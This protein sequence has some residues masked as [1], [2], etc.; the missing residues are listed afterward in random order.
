MGT[1]SKFADSP[2]QIRKEGQEITLRFTKTGPTTGRV[3]W[4]IPLPS[5]G[6]DV[7][8]AGAYN[9]IVITVASKAANYLSTSPQNGTFYTGD[10]SVDPDLNTGDRLDGAMVLAALY[11]D[12]T[13]TSIDLTDLSDK[14]VYYISG[15]AVDNVCRYHREGVHSYSLP[16]GAEEGGTPDKAAYHNVQIDVIGGIPP[17]T[18]TGLVPD[19]NYTLKLTLD[20]VDYSVVVAGEDAVTYADLVTELNIQLALLGDVFSSPLAPHTNELYYNPTARTLSTWSGTAA[21]AT[22]VLTSVADPTTQTIGD[23]WY[24]PSTK[25]LKKYD[26]SVWNDKT[27]IINPFDPT[28]PSCNQTWFDGTH[29]WIYKLSHWQQ[30]PTYITNRNP[31]MAPLLSCDN[32]WYNTDTLVLSVWDVTLMRWNPVDAIYSDIDPNSFDDG[33]YWYD[34][35]AGV[36]NIRASSAWN[37][38]PNVAYLDTAGTNAFA[39]VPDADNYVF[40]KDTHKL[41]KLNMSLTWDAQDVVAFPTDPANRTLNKLWWNSTTGIDNLFYWDLLSSAW[42]AVT[43]FVQTNI[44]PSL[45]PTITDDAAWYNPDTK[46]VKLIF[47]A[48]CAATYPILYSQNP[49]SLSSGTI[50]YDTTS[51]LWYSWNGSAFVQVFPFYYETDP[52]IVVT[53]YYWY[54]L[55]HSLLKKWTGTSWVSVTF[56]THPVVNPIPS[57]WFNTVNDTLY[58]W[59]GTGWDVSPGI[60]ACE[61]IPAPS[62]TDRSTLSFF[63]CG[64]GCA[65]SLFLDTS[66]AGLL[67]TQLKQ[68]VIY[69][70][71]VLGVSGLTGGSMTRHLGVGD[72]G[73]PD[74]RRQLHATIRSL[75][76]GSVAVQVELTKEQLDICIDNA[77]STLRKH[78][79]YSVYRGFFFVDFLPNQQTYILSNRCVGFN[80]ITSINSLHR[81]RGSILKANA[82]GNDVFAF[83]AMQQ[84][85]SGIGTFDILSFHLIAG[86]MK[87]LETLFAEQIMFTWRERSRE[88]SIQQTMG[89]KER[90]L[91]DAFIERTEQEL[92]TDRQTTNFIRGWAVAEAK[93][94]LAQIRGK[95]TQLPGPNGS[96]T[97]NATD[98]SSQAETEMTDLMEQL[99]DAGEMQDLIGVGMR[100]HFFIG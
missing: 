54:D 26:G 55:A 8:G 24:T 15:Y 36:L 13:T 27:F 45:P 84:L 77:L 42:V 29:V 58:V 56:V 86:Y 76:G 94:I 51:N 60:V 83:S 9:G 82:F 21:V 61:L 18:L 38:V 14:T 3:S 99:R 30:L 31:L 32:Y 34:E 85:Y 20:N 67:L 1:F 44:D 62:S 95:Y 11:D 52:Y 87:E 71:A 47:N 43:A 97:L 90:V 88:L 53:G 22:P 37:V 12:K 46:D 59:N 64:I 50:W 89:A 80:K 68:S 41:Y 40:V 25:T 73:S 35:T 63:T 72:D 91:V 10:T 17:A 39:S 2:D 19:V 93:K 16:T 5:V 49:L 74:E 75:L 96:T 28:T 33:D 57:Y 69:L 100:A 7:S 6:C 48:S 23:L 4:N 70:D 78:S 79:S 98:L 66:T 65:Q 92:M 81:M